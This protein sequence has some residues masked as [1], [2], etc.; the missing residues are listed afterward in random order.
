VRRYNIGTVLRGSLGWP[1]CNAE[2][3][4][5]FSNKICWSNFIK[6]HSETVMVWNYQ[7]A[8]CS[9]KNKFVVLPI[10]KSAHFSSLYVCYPRSWLGLVALR[11]SVCYVLPDLRVT[12][13]FHIIQIHWRPTAV[14]SVRTAGAKARRIL[15]ARVKVVTQYFKI[16]FGDNIQTARQLRN[17]V[18]AKFFDVIVVVN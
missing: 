17:A 14:D 12:W 9:L 7:N 1:F 15:S 10:I 11:Y 8:D 18:F 6:Q 4:I 2:I 5:H 13:C 3:L 16:Q